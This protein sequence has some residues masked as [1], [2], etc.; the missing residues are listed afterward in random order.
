MKMTSTSGGSGNSVTSLSLLAKLRDD[1]IEHQA[2][3]QFVHRYAPQIRAWCQRWGLQE[4]DA[5]DVTQ[6]VL[7]KLARQMH[8]FEYDPRGKFRAWLKTIAWRAWA[9][10]L[11]KRGRDPAR[12][13]ADA[14]LLQLNS[15]EAKDDL[16]RRL[17]EEADRE[18]LEIAMSNVKL[19][20]KPHT[21][22][23]FRLM[24]F[25]GKSGVEAAEALGIKL[26]SVF[27]AK[28]RIDR[29]ITKEI[30]ALDGGSQ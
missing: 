17:D 7:L 23:A 4:A 2:W 19:R 10:F 5:Q 27:V 28:S 30:Q 3:D 8:K 22:E 26:G 1:P 18:Q 11:R 15:L 14:A 12:P 24:T 25:E 13:G 6:D 9:D 29:M 16:M 21:F 20:V